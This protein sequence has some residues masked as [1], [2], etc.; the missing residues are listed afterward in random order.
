LDFADRSLTDGG[1]GLRHLRPIDI[2][3]LLG[4]LADR[5]ALL[6][7]THRSEIKLLLALVPNHM[8]GRQPWFAQATPARTPR[9][10]AWNAP[11]LMRFLDNHRYGG[12]SM[13]SATLIMT[14]V[15][16]AFLAA[17]A[18]AQQYPYS[19]PWCGGSI[20]DPTSNCGFTSF[21]QCMESMLPFGS[22]AQCVRNPWYRGPAARYRR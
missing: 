11:R 8:S 16:G 13:R 21:Q 7:A 9:K 2:D 15:A 17:P 12:I 1:F 3:P 19:Y 20:S 18:K 22:R 4:A 5:E 10:A 6:E 14:V